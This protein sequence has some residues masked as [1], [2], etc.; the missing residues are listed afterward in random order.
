LYK[1]IIFVALLFQHPGGE[2]ILLDQAGKGLRAVY[3]RCPQSGMVCPVWTFFI[4]GFFS[5][6]RPHFLS[7]KNFKLFEISVV[8]VHRQEWLSPCRQGRSICGDIFYGWPLIKVA[9]YL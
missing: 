2:D 9:K 8:F 5:G 4:Q 7:A 1:Y 6:A 3:K